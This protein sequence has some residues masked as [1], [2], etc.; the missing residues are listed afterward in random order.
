MLSQS[1]TLE[2][3]RRASQIISTP[4]AREAKFLFLV[5]SKAGFRLGTT[6]R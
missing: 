5:I 1:R 4:P 3:K 2:R 6:L